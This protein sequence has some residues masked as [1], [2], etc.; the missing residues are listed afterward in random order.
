[1]IEVHQVASVLD[2]FIFEQLQPFLDVQLAEGIGFQTDQLISGF[3]DRVDLLLQSPSACGV[4][5]D[6]HHLHDLPGRGNDGRRDH[7]QKLLVFDIQGVT[8]GAGE[9]SRVRVSGWSGAV[10]RYVVRMTV[11]RVGG[12]RGDLRTK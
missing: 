12:L 5:D 3:V 10:G 7:L 6:G 4:P 2:D 1:M 8:L 11:L 9:I